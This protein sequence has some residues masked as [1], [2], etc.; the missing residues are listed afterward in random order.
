MV[1]AA[2]AA[3]ARL[4]LAVSIPFWLPDF[5]LAKLT[6]SEM[7]VSSVIVALQIALLLL[8][9]CSRKYWIVWIALAM[10]ITVHLSFI[11]LEIL[12]RYE[13]W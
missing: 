10:L 4:Y 13:T 12:H 5:F 1:L 3:G 7:V 2:P 6:V 11:P 8:A 9:I